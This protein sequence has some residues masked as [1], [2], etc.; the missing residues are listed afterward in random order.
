MM[1]MMLSNDALANGVITTGNTGL[2]NGL[3]QGWGRAFL[4]TMEIARIRI[5]AR[6]YHSV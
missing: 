3:S 5:Q 1:M 4:K 2:E 6:G